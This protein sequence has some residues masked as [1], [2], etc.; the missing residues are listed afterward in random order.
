M[1]RFLRLGLHDGGQVDYLD[2]AHIVH[3]RER[4]ASGGK[5][6]R[7]LEVHVHFTGGSTTQLTGAAARE[8]LG[9]FRA[10]VERLHFQ[11][12]PVSGPGHSALS[13]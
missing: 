8:F 5:D 12:P 2:L 4:D 3:V 11:T 10:Y 7:G 6:D 9:Q 1:V 13:P